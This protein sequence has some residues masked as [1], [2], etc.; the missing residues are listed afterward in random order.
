MS[1]KIKRRIVIDIA[2]DG[3]IDVESSAFFIAG[4][5]RQIKKCLER[6]FKVSRRNYRVQQNK[7]QS[8]KELRDGDSGPGAKSNIN[9]EG[10]GVASTSGKDAN[11]AEGRSLSSR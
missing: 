4:E 3:V 6:W 9:S 1:L 11:T 8:E 2:E 7:I 5:M 10:T